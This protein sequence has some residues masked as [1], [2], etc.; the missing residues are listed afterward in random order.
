VPHS[1]FI[2]W[3]TKGLFLAADA[4]EFKKKQNPSAIPD[5]SFIILH[6]SHVPSMVHASQ[7][8]T[9]IFPAFAPGTLLLTART[10]LFV[11]TSYLDVQ[12]LPS[13]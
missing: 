3:R 2:T 4:Q 1:I 8:E 12:G 9:I 5:T 6:D 10:A 11:G 7:R 13:G